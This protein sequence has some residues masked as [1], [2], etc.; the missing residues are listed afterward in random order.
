[1]AIKLTSL[2]SQNADNVEL[3]RVKL[4]LWLSELNPNLDFNSGVLHDILLLSGAAQYAGFSTEFERLRLSQSLLGITQTP[5][6]SDAD[7]VDS[8]LSNYG[9]SRAAGTKSTGS[10]AIVLSRSTDLVLPA[11]SEFLAN[12]VTYSTS[13][14]FAAKSKSV[15]VRT[16]SDR[17]LLPL[18][19]STWVFLVTVTASVGYCRQAY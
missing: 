1:M 2:L 9:I 13:Q 10:L 18:T 15:D 19:D 5:G 8:L 3:A 7:I 16:T 12:G 6:L 11:G 14:T 17:L 4:R